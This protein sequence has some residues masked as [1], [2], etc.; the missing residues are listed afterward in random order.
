TEENLEK[1]FTQIYDKLENGKNEKYKD[2][3]ATNG[4][5][6]Y[7]KLREDW[8]NTNRKHIW[9]VLVKGAAPTSTPQ[10]LKEFESSPP[11]IDC[12][13]QFL[14]WMTEWGEHY[15]KKQKEEYEKV[16]DKCTSC[17]ATPATGGGTATCDKDKCTQCHQACNK[18]KEEVQKWLND[19][20]KQ[21][22]KYQKLYTQAT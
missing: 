12:T 8:W 9:K 17:T 6:K 14:R 20:T 4:E 10:C 22:T 3:S 15:C 7:K 5:P 1:I 2:D 16:K 19:W 21:E 13:P 11:D 18:Y